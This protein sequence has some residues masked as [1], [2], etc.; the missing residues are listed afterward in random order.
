MPGRV[1]RGESGQA[2]VE[3]VAIGVAIIVVVVACGALWRFG[4]EGGF[5]RVAQS[6]ASHAIE[7]AGGLVDVLLY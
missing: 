5:A 3:Y 1:W 4:S 6:H 2:S 7:E